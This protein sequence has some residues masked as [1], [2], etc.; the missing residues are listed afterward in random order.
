MK[1]DGRR[2]SNV[3]DRRGSAARRA[4][5]PL[6]LG[7]IGLIIVFLVLGGDP[8]T[9]LQVLQSQPESQGSTGARAPGQDATAEFI[10]VVLA[11]T[12]DVWTDLFQKSGSR[13]PTP[14]LVLFDDQVQSACGFQSAA[15]GPF[16]CPADQKVYIDLSFF[17]QLEKL[18]GKGDFAQAYVLAHEVGHHIQTI[19]GVSG[20]LHKLKQG[21][22]EAEQNALSVRQELQ[23]DCYAGVWAHHADAQR[24]VLE[25]GDVEEGLRAAA[26]IGD[27]A[28]QKRSQG[29]TVPETWTHGSSEMRAKWFRMGLDTG[30]IDACDTYKGPL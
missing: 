24:Q 3:D 20:E 8:Q 23:A 1:K 10:S 12:E 6:G 17:G 2:S 25:S 19:T 30:A 11:D 27:D 5:V 26:A 22:P 7:G 18:G 14:T 21:R 4:G 9:V 29:Y 15:V 13:Y 28:L 16:Y